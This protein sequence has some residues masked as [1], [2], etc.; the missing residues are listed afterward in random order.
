MIGIDA[1]VDD[2]DDAGPGYARV[3]A[4]REANRTRGRLGNVSSPCLRAEVIDDCSIAERCLGRLRPSSAGPLIPR[5]FS[6]SAR[7]PAAAGHEGRLYATERR[8][9]PAIGCTV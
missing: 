2:R 3:L 7:D 6:A 5:G 1:R 8:P 9:L 4:R